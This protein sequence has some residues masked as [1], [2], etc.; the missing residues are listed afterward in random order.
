MNVRVTGKDLRWKWE[1]SGAIGIVESFQNREGI[2]SIYFPHLAHP[3]G[4]EVPCIL[5]FEQYQL[6]RMP[7]RRLPYWKRKKRK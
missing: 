4:A 1:W 5:F 2:Y 6:E 7:G 3:I